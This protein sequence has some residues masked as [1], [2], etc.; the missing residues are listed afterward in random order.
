[1]I[2]HI[3]AGPLRE[4]LAGLRPDAAGKMGR[5]WRNRSNITRWAWE[6]CAAKLGNRQLAGILY[7]AC[8][9]LSGERFEPA[10]WSPEQWETLARLI[11]SYQAEKPDKALSRFEF[12]RRN[13]PDMV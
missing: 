12:E 7:A 5:A 4:A 10:G 8:A 9:E 2:P 6:N 13:S 3:D 1:M 11:E